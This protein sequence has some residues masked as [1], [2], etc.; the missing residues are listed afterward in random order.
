MW[1]KNERKYCEFKNKWDNN[2]VW[3][4]KIEGKILLI[5]NKRDIILSMKNENLI[6]E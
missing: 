6:V 2:T 1:I 4:W 5:K 3:I